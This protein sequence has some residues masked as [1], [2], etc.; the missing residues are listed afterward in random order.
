MALR[1]PWTGLIL[2]FLPAFCS[3]LL[4]LLLICGQAAAPALAGLEQRVGR[5][6]DGDVVHVVEFTVQ[7][8]SNLPLPVLPGSILR[9]RL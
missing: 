7:F 5:P 6:G 9:D 8:T 4:T 3:S 2:P 1:L